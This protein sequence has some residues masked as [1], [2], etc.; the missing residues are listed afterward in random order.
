MK[1]FMK[2]R[3]WIILPIC[4]LGF[5]I[6]SSVCPKNEAPTVTVAAVPTACFFGQT[7]AVT[8]TATDPDGDALT[9][10]WTT[11][12]GTFTTATTGAAVTW[13]APNTAGAYT[14]TVTVNDGENTV[15]ASAT[16]T[17]TAPPAQW[18][19]YDD[20]NYEDYF[21]S[22]QDVWFILVLFD[23]P[24]GW[25]D[26]KVTE[27]KIDF[28]TDGDPD[29]ISPCLW[30]TVYDQGNYWPNQPEYI[31]EPE[32]NPTNGWQYYTVDWDLDLDRFCA[33]YF[34]LYYADDPDPWYDTS[35]PD[36]RAYLVDGPNENNLTVHLYNDIDWAIQVY[37]EHAAAGAAGGREGMW[38]E[39][40]KVS[41][42]DHEKN[43]RMDL[44]LQKNVL[45]KATGLKK[46][47]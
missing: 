5:L 8:A 31:D 37:V 24:T 45:K 29:G 20:E 23:K 32:Y 22:N 12:G 3:N 39:G 27:M 21:D 18:I 33:G 40:H 34:Q 35:D 44:P 47:L 25:T 14:I 11:T 15:N 2:S 26:Y 13:Q 7:S 46:E 19:A 42:K 4:I 1:R 9:Y 36:I 10:S 17:V 16:I 38:I 6:I 43:T 28:H 30:N 41:I